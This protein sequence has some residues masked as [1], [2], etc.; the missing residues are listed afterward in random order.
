MQF[1][2]TVTFYYCK[3]EQLTSSLCRN[4]YKY[5]YIYLKPLCSLCP[6][7]SRTTMHML[8]APPMPH[9]DPTPFP[10]FRLTPS[11]TYLRSCPCILPTRPP[12]SPCFPCPTL[13]SRHPV[14]G[15]HPP[16]PPSPPGLSLASPTPLRPH[17]YPI[18]VCRN[19]PVIF[20][21]V[22]TFVYLQGQ[23]GNA[24]GGGKGGGSSRLG[25]R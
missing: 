12:R 21:A 8:P 5:I 23:P 24:G 10:T 7:Y 13:V 18:Y 22:F 17:P 25:V 14:P 11:P 15:F 20:G 16:G 6:F 19:A 9:P 1:T 2:V 4:K 3:L